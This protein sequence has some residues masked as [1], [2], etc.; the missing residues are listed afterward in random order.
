MR[1]ESPELKFVV[2]SGAISSHFLPNDL[3]SSARIV[4]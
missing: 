2:E 3:A 1:F 4:I